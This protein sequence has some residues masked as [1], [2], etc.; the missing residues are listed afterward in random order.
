MI[1]I[2]SISF[3]SLFILLFSY[4]QMSYATRY[5]G[6][7]GSYQMNL[8]ANNSV[9]AQTPTIGSNNEEY[10]S[11]APPNKEGIEVNE[12]TSQPSGMVTCRVHYIIGTSYLRSEYAYHRVFAYMPEA[13]FTLKGLTAYRINSNTFFTLYSNNGITQDW[14]NIEAHGCTAN[15]TGPLDT[16]YFTVQFPFEVR[17]YVKELPLDGKVVIPQAMIAGYTRMFENTGKPTVNVPADKATVKLNLAPSIINFPSNCTSNIDN[18]NINHQSLDSTEF[19]S[20]ETR[21]VTYQ[22]E[23]AQSVKV[24]I[25]LDYVTDS[26]PQKR[27]PLKS[28]SNTIYSELMLYDDSSNLRG[29]TIETTIEKIKNI[30]V[31][32]HLSGLDAEPG[33]YSGSAWIIA[34]YL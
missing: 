32:S 22:C 6:S 3:I 26:D 2:K 18:L 17:I 7:G 15:I 14:K 33:K 27:L 20:K 30:Q 9:V 8:V 24:K 31:E 19:D 13:G 16:S 5:S 11:I 12:S 34:T 23:K 4:N 1:N 21:T 10:Y 29:K 25:S 28:G